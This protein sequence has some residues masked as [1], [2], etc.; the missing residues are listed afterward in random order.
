MVVAYYANVPYE[1]NRFWR[2]FLKGNPP[3]N[4][5]VTEFDG[6]RDVALNL[7]CLGVSDKLDLETS[8]EKDTRMG[9]AIRQM[10]DYIKS[11]YKI[12]DNG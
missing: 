7:G 1:Y 8:I 9:R 6:M 3:E 2:I 4:R 5:P 11:H 10:P 12:E